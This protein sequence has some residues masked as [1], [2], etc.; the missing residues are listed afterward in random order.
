[1][2]KQYTLT[3]DDYRILLRRV[4]NPC[5]SCSRG[6]RD[7]DYGYCGCGREEEC[8]KKKKYDAFVK[9]AEDANLMELYRLL[10]RVDALLAQKKEIEKKLNE[11]GAEISNEFGTKVLMEISH[12]LYKCEF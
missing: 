8:E 9:R 11:V 4:P 12:N 10:S 1:M 5:D 6:P 2:V 7:G 3:V